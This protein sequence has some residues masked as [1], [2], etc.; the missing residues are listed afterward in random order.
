[1][2]ILPAESVFLR[3]LRSKVLA[4]VMACIAAVPLFAQELI[5]SLL[6]GEEY[7]ISTS[8]IRSIKFVANNMA[9]YQNDGSI[10]WWDLSEIAHYTFDLTSLHTM[11]PGA[12][13]SKSL[14]VYPNP[15]QGRVFI[16]YSAFHESDVRIEILDFSGKVVGLLYDGAHRDTIR[17]YWDAYTNRVAP[18]MYLC[19]V[20]SRDRVSTEKFI[21]Q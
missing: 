2:K 3:S 8:Q 9:I 17:V 20:G 19:R 5:V 18:G 11:H 21:V 7:E 12:R 14:H 10:V 13:P 1:M 4:L 6:D 15:S 16:E